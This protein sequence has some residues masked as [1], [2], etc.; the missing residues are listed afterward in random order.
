M[1]LLQV[2]AVAYL[3]VKFTQFI[4]IVFISLCSQTTHTDSNMHYF[5]YSSEIDEQ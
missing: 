4:L 2:C 3:A 1:Y 5:K